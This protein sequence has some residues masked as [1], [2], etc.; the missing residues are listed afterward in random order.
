MKLN[1]DNCNLF[2]TGYKSENVWVHI[3]TKK[4]WESNKH[5]LLRVD[6]DRNLNFNKYVSPLCRKVGKSCL[7]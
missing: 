4:N 3:W 2:A 7:F 5:K 6:N 1:R